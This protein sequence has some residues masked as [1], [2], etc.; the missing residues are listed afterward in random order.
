MDLPSLAKATLIDTIT[1]EQIP[2]MYNPEQYTLEQANDFAEIGIPGLAAPPIQY[3][4][5]RARTLSMDLF[6]DSYELKRDVRD[7]SGRVVALLSQRPVT[8]AP[9]IL[10][11]VMGAFSFRCVLLSASQ[12][13][14]MFSRDGT[15][16][17]ATLSVRFQEYADVPLSIASGIS[18]LLSAVVPATASRT[19]D[20]IASDTL[21][22]PAR[23]RDIAVANNLDDALNIPT[24]LNLVV[25]G[26]GR[27]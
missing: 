25:P 16:V 21:G 24:G 2:V 3:V 26:S 20:Q 9:P 1:N 4:R 13:Y 5:G 6:F 14:T 12:R 22:D 7:F 8:F 23:W 15:P 18:S 17:R 10:L 27:K 19:L 11:F